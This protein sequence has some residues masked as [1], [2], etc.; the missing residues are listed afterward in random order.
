MNKLSKKVLPLY[1]LE[2]ELWLGFIIK[3][4]KKSF[5]EYSKKQVC[6]A[7]NSMETT[8][9]NWWHLRIVSSE[10]QEE[11]TCESVKQCCSLDFFFNWSII[12]LQFCT[13]FCST[14]EWVSYMWTY[15]PSL[16]HLPRTPPAHPSPSSQN[17][18]PLVHYGRFPAAILHT[19]VYLSQ[20]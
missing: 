7:T 14:V 3:F 16:S 13:N 15:I 9:Q 8:H 5:F 18:E 4:L 20:T 1:K 12:D 17:M 2:M 10:S 6:R 19:V 11:E